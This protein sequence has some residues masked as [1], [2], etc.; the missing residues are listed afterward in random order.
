MI[1]RDLD[2]IY[3]IVLTQYKHG[4]T[5][6][7][8]AAICN[9]EADEIKR[10]FKKYG[11]GKRDQSKEQTPKVVEMLKEGF[12]VKE[13]AD[14]VGLSESWVIKIA[15]ENNISPVT[16][17]KRERA[18]LIAFVQQYKSKGLTAQEISDRFGVNFSFVRKYTKG[19]CS[20]AV[21]PLSEREEKAK[22]IIESNY[23]GIEYVGGY[24]HS[25]SPVT[26]RCIKCGTVFERSMISIRHRD[27]KG[28]PHCA[29]VER[30]EAERKKAEA[31]EKEQQERKAFQR[32]ESARKKAEAKA[33]A[34]K[35]RELKRQDRIH[36]CPVC[37]KITDRPKFCCDQCATRAYNT[38]HEVR[39]RTKV[40]S[41]LV[42]KGITLKR[43][44]KREHGICY[45]CGGVCD[46][47]DKEEKD[48]TIICGDRYPSIDHV[49]PLAKGGLHSWENVKLAHR[50]CNSKKSAKLPTT[51][52]SRTTSR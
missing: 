20:Q 23:E 19:I 22:Q 42:D 14:H 38:A 33:Q 31:R 47:D 29:E 44:Y 25:D 2:S 26:L 8:C 45:L 7:E 11:T 41:V 18:R 48:G 49:I 39:R 13:V 50:I 35:E 17:V 52:S 4:K 6:E 46:W 34:E 16:E 27:T 40:K 15:Y 5:I 3:S 37:G 36:P 10:L 21:Q 32:E 51:I 9:C 1:W 43:L 12:T 30:K 24:T 28:C